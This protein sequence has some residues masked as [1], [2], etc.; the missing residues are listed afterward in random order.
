MLLGNLRVTPASRAIELEHS[1]LRT[2]PE[3]VNPVF[4][5]VEGKKSPVRL[6]AYRRRR[7]QHDRGRK[8]GERLPVLATA[9]V[10]HR[11]PMKHGSILVTGGAGYIGSHV[12]L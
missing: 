8:P 11:C 1:Q 3:L 7:V 4:V 2:R 10:Y 12:V 6:E 5:A 9:F